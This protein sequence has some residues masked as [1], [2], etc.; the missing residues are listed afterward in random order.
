MI[1]SSHSQK[2]EKTSESVWDIKLIPWRKLNT[3][4]RNR[5]LVAFCVTLLAWGVGG[6]AWLESKLGTGDALIFWVCVSIPFICLL[7]FQHLRQ[8]TVWQWMEAKTLH[9]EA[10]CLD[11]VEG[12]E[13]WGIRIKASFEFQ[14]SLWVVTPET[15]GYSFPSEG[16]ARAFLLEHIGDDG[17]MTL[18]VDL[19]NPL[20]TRI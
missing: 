9:Y 6:V 13:R 11:L 7:R 17:E 18:Q 3:L 19:N 4:G 8:K 5:I 14:E 12:H 2:L 15:T 20:H 10:R 16:S 1:R